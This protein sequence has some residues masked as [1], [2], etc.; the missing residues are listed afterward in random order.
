MIRKPEH[1]PVWLRELLFDPKERMRSLFSSEPER[2]WRTMQRIQD[3]G[4]GSLIFDIVIEYERH[5]IDE[6]KKN[7][8]LKQALRSLSERISALEEHKG[9][10][11]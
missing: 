3:G 9:E 11:K 4:V 7:E 6:Q 8:R 5:I 1:Y 10:S 2:N